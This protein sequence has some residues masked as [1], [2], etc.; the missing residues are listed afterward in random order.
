M[1]KDYDKYM[2]TKEAILSSIETALYFRKYIDY[3]PMTTKKKVKK[4]SNKVKELK[5]QITEGEFDEYL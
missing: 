2:Y 3:T 5:K 4:A 1:S